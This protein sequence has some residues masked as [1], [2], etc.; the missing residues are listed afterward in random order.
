MNEPGPLLFNPTRASTEELEQTF[1]GREDLL[2][3]LHNDLVADAAGPSVRHF[4]LVGPR[5]SGKSHL[6]ELLARRIESSGA[7]AV[8]RLP[9][10]QY[11]IAGLADLLEQVWVRLGGE[12]APFEGER[13][14]GR[15]EELAVDAIRRWREAEDRPVLVV[16]ENL[17]TFFE[18][19]LRGR[20]DQ[21]RLRSLLQKDP[22]FTLLATSTSY[23]G[24]AANHDAPFYDF[25]Q[26][27]TLEELSRDE[28]RRLVELRAEWDEERELLDHL[29]QLRPRLDAVYHLSGGNPRLALALYA[30]LR[31]GVS[32]KLHR[33]VLQLLDEV[34]P[35]YQARLRDVSAQMER[36]LTEMA[37]AEGPLTP[38]EI[39]RRCRMATN[40]VTA[41][42]SKLVDERF[43]RP[44]GRPDRR[45]RYYELT[46]R[47]FRLW[48]QMREDP[49]SGGKLRFLVEFYQRWDAGYPEEWRERVE[50]ASRDL[51]LDLAEHRNPEVAD[52][53]RTLDY[54]IEAG[55]GSLAD[56]ACD[57]IESV[58]ID[59]P[60]ATRS[61]ARRGLL[62]R[63]RSG[64]YSSPYKSWAQFVV[65]LDENRAGEAVLR[66]LEG[67]S[68][69]GGIPTRYWDA[70]AWG[71]DVT[72]DYEIGLEV[73]ER[74][75]AEHPRHLPLRAMGCIL[76]LEAG[77]DAKAESFF[78]DCMQGVDSLVGSLDIGQWCLR[79]FRHRRPTWADRVLS[80]VPDE[81]VV[82]AVRFVT[83]ARQSG[84]HYADRFAA[85]EFDA[86]S[87]TARS[88][89]W[90]K[91]LC[92]I[93]LTARGDSSKA[94]RAW[95][96]L[97]AR[98]VGFHAGPL[99]A[100]VAETLIRFS[101]SQTVLSAD[102]VQWLRINVSGPPLEAAFS[103]TV[104]D[105]VGE[106]SGLAE[107]S[108]RVYSQLRE[109]AV[110]GRDLEPWATALRILD[111]PNKTRALAALH[112]EEREAVQLL[113]GDD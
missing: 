24:A 57:A 32:E 3:Q 26:V 25:F 109:Q 55:D 79:L 7:W 88:P 94:I 37:L 48:L 18:R 43:V 72:G 11:R 28:V 103:R 92:A 16:L 95:L 42:V 10:E 87:W 17:S 60:S 91:A 74:G 107:P 104:V 58:Y 84:P 106:E 54:M 105:L 45:R 66:L 97:D 51:W 81:S 110:L 100:D 35:Y 90:F 63:E 82:R 34:T 112:P 13:D 98:R 2:Q 30:V 65:L 20:R 102:M 61:A 49:R 53:M 5:G 76:A 31:R 50:G 12:R 59:L 8:V 6:T 78:V 99:G 14:P 39:A 96:S 29:D 73:V 9:E 71:C 75:L 77:D 64:T 27:R 67:L 36:V 46:D 21:A 19:K 15:V 4:Q 62:V 113:L 93:V 52:R 68:G 111:C 83:E 56:V 89:S 38:S 70:V 22:L 101:V 80:V 47:L 69:T 23:L 41:N 1:V 86:S 44:G 85:L 108:M 33:Q 40:Q